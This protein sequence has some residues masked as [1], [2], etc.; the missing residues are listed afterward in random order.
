MPFFMT[1]NLK[2]QTQQIVDALNEVYNIEELLRNH[3]IVYPQKCRS[4]ADLLLLCEKYL[5]KDIR[6]MTHETQWDGGSIVAFIVTYQT[7]FD[8][9]L[10]DGMNHCHQTFA[11][12]KEL[13]HTII[14]NAEF[15]SIDF[16]NTI[17]ECY[18]GGSLSGIAASEYTA[19][20]AAMEYLFPFKDRLKIVQQETIDFDAVAQEYKIPRLRIEKYLTPFRMET[21]KKCYSASSYAKVVE[22]V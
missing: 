15:R 16:E 6:V 17:D 14:Q 22:T 11:L 3:S 13:F 4:D 1:I 10:L 5:E 12:C 8:I 7:Y 9:C 19:E 21:L 20:I 2:I 18:A